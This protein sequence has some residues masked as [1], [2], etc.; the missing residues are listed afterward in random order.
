M[1]RLISIFALLLLVTINITSAEA[2]S[3]T[4]APLLRT[5]NAI[6]NRYIVVL[7]TD[8]AARTILP[9]MGITAAHIYDTVLNGFTATL[10]DS[11][12]NALRHNPAVDYIE[13]DGL[14]TVEPIPS[15]A[16]ERA[17]EGPSITATTQYMD[18]NGDPWGLDRI[19]QHNLPLSGTYTYNGTG[20]SVYAYII[21]TGIWT[22]H[23]EFGG[24]A[25]NVY[26][27]LGGTGLDCNGHGT[28]MA[29]VV[30]STTYGVAKQAKLRG[31]RV[32]D[33]NGAG[34]FSA[35]IAGVNWVAANH[36]NPAVAN[37]PL[38]GSL[39]TTLNTAVAN[40]I[41][42]GV[43][44]TV[45]AGASNANACNYSPGSVTTA[46]TVATTDKTDTRASFS[47]YGSCVDIYAP[48]VAIKSTTL[49]NGIV[50]WSGT[51]GSS[52][53]VAGV[54]VLCAEAGLGSCSIARSTPGVV[55]NNPAGTP[56]RLAYMGGL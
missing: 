30:G 39:N 27:A 46:I 3:T 53:F 32:L 51:A 31:V 28:F 17:N 34:A 13:Q 23:V 1:K 37:I 15:V 9:T 49:N 36:A 52:A 38:G 20:A 10:N 44:T 54:E 48:G 8:K 4:L 33:C 16:I 26:D 25:T 45:S 29:G 11:Q 40:L 41:A 6:P 50:V 21:D 7:K 42:S 56:N 12:L 35:V 19:D 18:A 2:N 55:I 24:R 22:S 47:N 14:L 43:P 5:K